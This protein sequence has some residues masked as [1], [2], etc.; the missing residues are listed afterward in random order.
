MGNSSTGEVYDR[1]PYVAGSFYPDNPDELR[2][3]VNDLIAKAGEAEIKE[4]VRAII[5]PHAGYIFSGEV[6]AAGF[7]AI[8]GFRDYENIFLIGSS[9][10]STFPGASIYHRGDYITPLGKVKVNREIARI[11]TTKNEHISYYREAHEGE[12]SIEVQLPFIQTLFGNSVSIIPV[13]IGTNSI[14]TC[15]VIARSL[16]PWFTANNLFIISSDFSHYP[17]YRDAVKVDKTTSE[18]LITGNSSKFLRTLRTNMSLGITGLSTSMCGWTAALTLMELASGNENLGF[19]H[20]CYRNSGDS[21]YGDRSSVVGYHA[22]ALVEK[23]IPATKKAAP[24]EEQ[25]TE[26]FNLS[27]KE[28]KTLLSVARRSIENRLGSGNPAHPGINLLTPNLRQNCGA[29]VTLYSNGSLRGCIGKFMSDEPLWKVVGN[30]ALSSAFHDS[31]FAPLTNE[32]YNSVSVEVSVLTP[33]RRIDSIDEI[34]PGKHGV[35]IRKDSSSGTFLPQVA[36]G[37]EWTREELLGY[38]SRDK[39]RLG[40]DGWRDSEI[41]IYEAIVFGEQDQLN[42]QKT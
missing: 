17:E 37:K 27:D 38:I 23:S 4:N 39:A 29:F 22:I 12:H 36:E 28:K 9:H 34:T 30:M 16:E 21:P 18:A 14:A 25:V 26:L 32:E 40:W 13:I 1:R 3:M 7:A 41:Y 20:I 8:G 33:L 2:S 10:R 24:G 11:L 35:Y 15:E 5:I 19:K 6:A 31:R 42:R